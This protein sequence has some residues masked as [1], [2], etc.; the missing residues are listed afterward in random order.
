M[1]HPQDSH[2]LGGV[3]SCS[4][5]QGSTGRTPPILGRQQGS[6]TSYWR[7]QDAREADAL[8]RPGTHPLDGGQRSE[9][10]RGQTDPAKPNSYRWLPNILCHSAG[11]GSTEVDPMEAV[12]CPRCS[13]STVIAGSLGGWRGIKPRFVPLNTR[14]IHWDEG[15]ALHVGEVYCCSSCGLTWTSLEADKVRELV[16]AYGDDLAVSPAACAALQRS[17]GDR[18]PGPG[19]GDPALPRADPRDVG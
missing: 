5:P 9:A 11:S 19:G 3:G 12:C 1:R 13:A 18:R 7:G 8:H 2:T 16:E 14:P 6:L 4:H 17:G 10:S 15:I